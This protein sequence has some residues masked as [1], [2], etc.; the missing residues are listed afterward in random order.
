MQSAGH[1]IVLEGVDGAGTTTHT[2]LL[3]DALRAMHVPVH[4]S[5]E[6]SGGPIGSLLRLM[7]TGRVVSSGVGSGA[8]PPAWNAMA[9]LFAADRVDHLESELL[10]NLREGLTVVCDRYD[11]S[12]VAYQSLTGGGTEAIAWLREINVHARRPDLTIVLDV[13]PE[14]AA[15]RRRRRRGGAELFDNDDLQKRL[16][17]FYTGLERYFPDERIVHVDSAG[18]VADVAARVLAQVKPLLVAR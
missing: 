3:G 17:E 9:L 11:H 16:C 12:S 8:R 2:K 10:P 4:L 15:E 13:L 1:F 18:E 14:V 5:A 7:L 6:P